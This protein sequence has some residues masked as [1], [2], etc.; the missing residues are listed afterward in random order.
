MHFI[1]PVAEERLQDICE[2]LAVQFEPFTLTL[3][4]PRQWSGGLMV[5][6][7]AIVPNGLVR[8]HTM[9]GHALERLSLPVSQR[10][11]SPHI[12]LAR[13]CKDMEVP[14]TC[15]SINWSVSSYALAVSTG[16]AD[17]RYELISRYPALK[18]G[19]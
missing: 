9:L 18:T 1:G 13:S 12:T 14:T 4:T 15:A 8:L 3:D 11:F 17:R 7:P 2:H 10:E 6:C 19:A 16:D 5:L